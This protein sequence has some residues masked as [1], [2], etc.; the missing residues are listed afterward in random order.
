MQVR[1]CDCQFN[2]LDLAGGLEHARRLLKSVSNLQNLIVLPQ[3]LYL[4]RF[5]ENFKVRQTSGS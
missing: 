4:L 5:I 2:R 1:R 3:K